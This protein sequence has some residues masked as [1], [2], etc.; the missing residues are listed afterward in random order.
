MP[1]QMEFYDE[2]LSRSFRQ[3]QEMMQT[4]ASSPRLDQLFVTCGA[5][6][7]QMNREVRQMSGSEKK[8]WKEILGFRAATGNELASTGTGW[9]L[10]S[11]QRLTEVNQRTIWLPSTQ[12]G[13]S[14][15]LVTC[16]I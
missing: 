12:Y 3:L 6:I 2:E 1:S 8:Q 14:W 13:L 10:P 5:Y 9:T 16:M 7:Q 4:D 15:L 11:I